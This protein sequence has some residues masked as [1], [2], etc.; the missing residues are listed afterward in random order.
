[1]RKVA[2]IH[3]GKTVV[4]DVVALN[5]HGHA[6]VLATVN[7]RQL[8]MVVKSDYRFVDVVPQRKKQ[9]KPGLYR[10]WERTTLKTGQPFQ[11]RDTAYAGWTKNGR[12]VPIDKGYYEYHEIA[13]Q[14]RG[15]WNT[16][17]PNST[18]IC[19]A[20]EPEPKEEIKLWQKPPLEEVEAKPLSLNPAGEGKASAKN[21]TK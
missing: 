18:F 2:F 1:M 12:K 11:A 9:G 7:G 14:F 10:S 20:R 21:F 6:T 3:A 17:T 8:Q 5:V 16:V 13:A 4:G 15:D 19:P